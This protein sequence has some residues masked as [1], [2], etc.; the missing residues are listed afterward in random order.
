[1]TLYGVYGVNNLNTVGGSFFCTPLPLIAS[2][3][4][5][6]KKRKA[7]LPS[8]PSDFGCIHIK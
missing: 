8:R 2:S 6:T 3:H 5:R 1:M 4:H 7:K